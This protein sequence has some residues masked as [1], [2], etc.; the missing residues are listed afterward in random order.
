MKCSD[1]QFELPLYGDG[2]SANADLIADH[3]AACPLCRQ[4]QA[5]MREIRASIGR[6]SRPEMP[7]SLRNSLKR[8]VAAEVSSAGHPWMAPDIRELLTMRVMPYGVGVFAS[9]LIGVTFLTML[10]S[11]IHGTTPRAD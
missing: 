10:F 9:L 6:L 3:L 5:D 4:L 2:V 11:G 8:K 7:V 1:L